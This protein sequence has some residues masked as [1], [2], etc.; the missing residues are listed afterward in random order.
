MGWGGGGEGG[1]ERVRGEPGCLPF[2]GVNWSV[3]GLGK[4]YSKFRTGKFR[5][6]IS[7]TICMNQFHLPKNDREDLK[8]VS[9]MAWKKWNTNFSLE[10]SVRK[11]RTTFSDVPLLREI[12]RWNDQKSHVPFTFQPGFLQSFCKW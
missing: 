7:F 1:G 6:G 12:F 8:L 3:R 9:T 5:P 11:N 2:T 4:R 10:Y